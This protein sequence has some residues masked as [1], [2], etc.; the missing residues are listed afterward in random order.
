MI[1]VVHWTEEEHIDV[2][3]VKTFGQ[4]VCKGESRD[5]ADKEMDISLLHKIKIYEYGERV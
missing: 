1:K 5:T 2:R 4:K 3:N